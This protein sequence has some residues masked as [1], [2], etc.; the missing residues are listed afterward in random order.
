MRAHSSAAVVKGMDGIATHEITPAWA[1]AIH[2][3]VGLTGGLLVGS[4]YMEST[5]GAGGLPANYSRYL[6]LA[7]FLR[8]MNKPFLIAGDWNI[9]PQDYHLM[10]LPELLPGTLV[11]T[12]EEGA[13]RSAKGNYSNIDYFIVSE[14]IEQAFKQPRAHTCWPACPHKPIIGCLKAKPNHIH[15]LT[16]KAPRSFPKGA[17]ASEG[18][19]PLLEPSTSRSTS[20]L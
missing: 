6:R 10:G 20:T 17:P 19:S 3:D 8:Y 11:H 15:V 14:G 5:S 9:S 12:S 2:S 13:C 7:Q 18:C 1:V 16:V 4:V